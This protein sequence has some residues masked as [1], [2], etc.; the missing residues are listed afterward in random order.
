MVLALPVRWRP[1]LVLAPVARQERE[2]AQEPVQLRRVVVLERELALV[3]QRLAL[4]AALPW[5][6]A[7][8]LARV[9]RWLSAVQLRRV[10]R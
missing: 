3:Q 8:R 9:K 10:W 4:Q 5:L 7:L 2:L 1:E 6:P